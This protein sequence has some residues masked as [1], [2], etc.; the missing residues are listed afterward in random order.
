M[1]GSRGASSAPAGRWWRTAAAVGT[2]SCSA[3][4]GEGRS[5]GTDLGTFSVAADETANECGPGALGSSP[6]W[7]FD[8][9]LL[10]ADTELF[11]D[12]RVGGDL[13]ADLSFEVAA[14]VSIDVR[15]ER[16]GAAGCAIARDDH[17]RGVFL[18]DAA[19]EL[20]AFTGEM[21]FDFAAAPGS[22]CSPEDGIVAGLPR[23]PC[24]MSY[25]LDG[26]RTRAPEF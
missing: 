23:L 14:S 24:H 9:E 4:P 17:I 13:H 18:P 19:G 21:R 2:L 20:T 15:P 12:G 26:N 1:A 7:A 6:Q 25:A 5:L 16:A 10:R 11:W 3:A 8:V 22:A